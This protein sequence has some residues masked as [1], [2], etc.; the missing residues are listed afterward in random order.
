MEFCCESLSYQVGP[1]G[2]VFRLEDT[3]CIQ[4]QS[5]VDHSAIFKQSGLICGKIKCFLAQPSWRHYIL[6]VNSVLF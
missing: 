4:K 1:V 6:Y 2:L 5:P 3:F